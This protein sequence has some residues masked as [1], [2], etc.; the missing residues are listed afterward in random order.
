MILIVQMR[1]PGAEVTSQQPPTAG[2]GQLEGKP[3]CKSHTFPGQ[4][5]ASLS[6]ICLYQ[7]CS[8]FSHKDFHENQILGPEVKGSLVLISLALV[9]LIHRVWMC[10]TI[11]VF[12]YTHA[13]TVTPTNTSGGQ[14]RRSG[15]HCPSKPPS[16]PSQEPQGALAWLPH[17]YSADLAQ[18][19]SCYFPKSNLSPRTK[20]RL[21]E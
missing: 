8:Q 15:P 13:G 4:F 21:L 5:P 10:A 3:T 14:S 11:S 16:E 9:W 18:R 12:S 7:T 2:K 17:I 19:T 1:K 20:I 6:L